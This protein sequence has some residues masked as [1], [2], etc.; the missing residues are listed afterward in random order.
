VLAGANRT[1][2]SDGHWGATVSRGVV[3]GFGITGYYL[4]LRD[5][6]AAR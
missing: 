2:M 1:A 3:T 4:A 5:M 6:L